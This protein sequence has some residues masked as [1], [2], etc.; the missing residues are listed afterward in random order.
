[1][2]KQLVLILAVLLFSES[3]LIA[4][5]DSIVSLPPITITATSEVG[6]SVNNAF[7]KTFPD[8][9]NVSW[10]K[11][12]KDYLSRFIENDMDHNALFKKNGVL[13]YDV[14]FGYSQNLPGDVLHT[15]EAAYPDHQITRT[16]RV[17]EGGRDIW[18]VNLE[19][20]KNYVTARI[21]NNEL[22]EVQRFNKS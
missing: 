20:I 9:M 13:K 22:E 14:S 10:Y 12:D 15:V 6:T 21:E 3:R 7:M 4:Q 17:K 5:N 2:K 1:M 19:G 8:A 16:F 11:F 18:V